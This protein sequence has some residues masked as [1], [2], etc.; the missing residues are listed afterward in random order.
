MFS[1]LSEPTSSWRKSRFKTCAK[2]SEELRAM[3]VSCDM[4]ISMRLSIVSHTLAFSAIICSKVRRWRL[5]L[6]LEPN[7]LPVVEGRC[8]IRAYSSQIPKLRIE[9]FRA[10]KGVEWAHRRIEPKNGPFKWHFR[11]VSFIAVNFQASVRKRLRIM[12]MTM[13]KYVSEY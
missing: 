7:G 4:R 2:A 3:H 10:E 1:I 11:D 13:G 8:C 6:S 5:V 12:I 9:C